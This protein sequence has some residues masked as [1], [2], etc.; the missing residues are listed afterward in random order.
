MPFCIG[1]A[2]RRVLSNLAPTD[3]VLDG[4]QYTSVEQ[5]FQAEKALRAGYVG[6]AEKIMANDNPREAKELGKQVP[7]AFCEGAQWC[8]AGGQEA[9]EVMLR[10]MLAKYEQ[11]LAAQQALLETGSA[12]L[13]ETTQ[14]DF[15]GAGFDHR[16]FQ[17]DRSLGVE[18]LR[19]P[20]GNWTGLLTMRVRERLN[21]RKEKAAW[22]AEFEAPPPQPAEPPVKEPK[23]PAKPPKEEKPKAPPASAEKGR[24]RVCKECKRRVC[25][26]AKGSRALG[27]LQLA[28]GTPVNVRRGPAPTGSR[29]SSVENIPETPD[30]AAKHRE[31]VMR[32]KEKLRRHRAGDGKRATS[33]P[34]PS[35]EVAPKNARRSREAEAPKEALAEPQDAG[36]AGQ[37]AP[38]KK[39]PNKKAK[40]AAKVADNAPADKPPAEKDQPAAEAAT[41]APMEEAG[42]VAEAPTE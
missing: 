42:P 11:C 18:P 36:L 34:D 3:Y 26:C 12:Y 37:K 9:L 23:Q 21:W 6:L 17:R 24:G 27:E 22:E 1:E 13:V 38:K 2:P 40:P 30:S 28:A 10:H 31:I 19:H 29:D 16:E 20:G 41:D 25:R 4:I 35:E 14:N 8:G 5:G 39:A 15:W 7:K 33:S 32:F